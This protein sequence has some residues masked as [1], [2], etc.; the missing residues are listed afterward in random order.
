MS[1]L[2]INIYGLFFLINVKV[3]F[4]CYIQLIPA[5]D[6]AVALK[7]GKFALDGMNI[8]KVLWTVADKQTPELT[9]YYKLYSFTR[10]PRKYIII[11]INR[12]I[13]AEENFMYI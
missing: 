10:K 11:N 1:L 4:R 2:I 8:S 5:F 3:G 12:K 7:Y 9:A 13:I 6:L